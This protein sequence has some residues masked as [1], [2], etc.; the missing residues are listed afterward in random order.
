MMDLGDVVLSEASRSQKD[1]PC[2]LGACRG[3][4]Q[5]SHTHRGGWRRQGL[6]GQRE[7]RVQRD[8]VP[9]WDDWVLESGSGGSCAVRT[10]SAPLDR[11][12]K[13]G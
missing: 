8:T 4:P 3:G 6:G 2:A 13:N 9:V 1:K 5:W 12:L 7:R 10:R 11:A